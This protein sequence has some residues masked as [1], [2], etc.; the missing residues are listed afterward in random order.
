MLET[1]YVCIDYAG[2]RTGANQTINVHTFETTE[3]VV[4]FKS[5]KGCHC[6]RV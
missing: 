4:N 6:T 5:M 2:K 3:T 1:N